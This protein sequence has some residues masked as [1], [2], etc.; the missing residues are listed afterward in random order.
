MMDWSRLISQEVGQESISDLSTFFTEVEPPGVS[1]IDTFYSD[2]RE[3][4]SQVSR[5]TDKMKWNGSMAIVALVSIT[6]NYF[7]SILVGVL[8]D[9]IVAQKHASKSTIGFGSAV[10][11]KQGGIERGA[12]ENTSFSEKIKIYE[13]TR[14]YIGVE[15]K[16]TDLDPIINEYGKVCELRHGIVHSS[17]YLA[18]KNALVLDI[19][20]SSK[21][22]LISIGYSEVQQVASICTT[23]IVSYNRHLFKCLCKRWAIDWRTEQWDKQK[24]D[25]TFKKIWNAFYSTEDKD[26]GSIPESGTW[27]KCRNRVK[28][29]Y[30][31]T[32]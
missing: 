10:W 25:Q 28:K 18:G 4:L 19:P 9:C 8:R 32:L 5:D 27:V 15:L 20:S 23:L 6:E 17:R 11:H 2:S 3:I 24:E 26:N 12:F 30:Q 14:K 29:E 7:R 21:H 1:A 31:I 22:L 13:A 16:G